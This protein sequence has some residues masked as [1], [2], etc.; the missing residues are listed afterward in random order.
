M[1]DGAPSVGAGTA[2]I[3]QTVG[4]GLGLIAGL[5]L[6]K[7]AIDMTKEVGKEAKKSVKSKSVH[8]ATYRPSR[9]TGD[10]RLDYMLGYKGG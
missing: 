1:T 6:A 8:V 4:A 9:S 5:Y 10:K 3:G 7:V 2:A